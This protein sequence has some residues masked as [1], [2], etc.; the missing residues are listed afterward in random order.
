MVIRSFAGAFLNDVDLKNFAALRN[1]AKGDG[2]FKAAIGEAAPVPV[3]SA[4]L[5]ERVSRTAQPILPTR[6]CLRCGSQLS[7]PDEQKEKR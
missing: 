1:P 5:L 6:S 2:L 4:A 3:L 7:A